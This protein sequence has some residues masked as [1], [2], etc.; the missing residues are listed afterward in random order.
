MGKKMGR[1]YT[2]ILMVKNMKAI[3]KMGKEL[4]LEYFLL[5]MGTLMKVSFGMA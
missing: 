2:R 5:K 4:D 1:E 3:I